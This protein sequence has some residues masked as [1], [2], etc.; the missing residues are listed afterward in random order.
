MA[1]RS[2]PDHCT[3]LREADAEMMLPANQLVADAELQYS[4]LLYP[5]RPLTDRWPPCEACLNWQRPAAVPHR[6]GAVGQTGFCIPG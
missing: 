4:S 5:P 1:G 6:A 2:G 3:T